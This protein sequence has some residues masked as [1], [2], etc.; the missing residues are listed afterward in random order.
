MIKHVLF[1]FSM[2]P[3]EKTFICWPVHSIDTGSYVFVYLKINN[4][5]T[6]EFCND[7]ELE[8]MEFNLKIM[9]QH[10]SSADGISCF[11][12]DI[13]AKMRS[14]LEQ[15]NIEINEDESKTHFTFCQNGTMGHVL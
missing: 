6:A 11:E 13:T 14:W 2:E 5:E 8:S 12:A 4:D 9:P 3:L 7:F 15:F 1:S 10:N